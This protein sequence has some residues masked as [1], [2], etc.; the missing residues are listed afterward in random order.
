MTLE[1]FAALT[2][3]AWRG[4]RYA[5]LWAPFACSLVRILRAEPRGALTAAQLA[6]LHNALDA[7]LSRRINL[8]PAP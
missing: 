8:P 1:T 6:E 3:W 7:A 2:T 4:W 5:W